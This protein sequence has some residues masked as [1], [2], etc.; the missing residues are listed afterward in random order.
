MV[1]VVRK[2]SMDRTAG[3][4]GIVAVRGSEVQ[5]RERERCADDTGEGGA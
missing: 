3:T 4:I 5:R 2:S 1:S